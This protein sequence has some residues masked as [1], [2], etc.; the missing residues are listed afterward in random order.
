MNEQGRILIEDA[1]SLSPVG[2]GP[3]GTRTPDLADANRALSQ[4]SYRPVTHAFIA[5]SAKL[6]HGARRAARGAFLLG[7]VFGLR[8]NLQGGPF[9]ALPP[10]DGLLRFLT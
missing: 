1:A 9:G 8:Y 10:R 2:G 6:Y 7:G 5:D 4:L 3:E